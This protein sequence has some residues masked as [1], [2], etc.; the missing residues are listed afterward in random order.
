[1]TTVLVFVEHELSEREMGSPLAELADLRV[2]GKRDLDRD[3]RRS[4]SR[5]LGVPADA[6]RGCGARHVSI[7]RP[8]RLTP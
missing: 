8:R 4:V 2:V 5:G 6:R 1:M 7:G 3:G